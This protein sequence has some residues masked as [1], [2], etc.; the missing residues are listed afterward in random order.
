M[1]RRAGMCWN[2]WFQVN[3]T[4]PTWPGSFDGVQEIRV[5]AANNGELSGSTA[6]HAF[7]PEYAEIMS[8]AMESEGKAYSAK[9]TSERE[10]H[11]VLH[12]AK[13]DDH[14]AVI[15]TPKY[16]LVEYNIWSSA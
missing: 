15:F 11:A 7:L 2:V 5:I 4:G 3:S 8:F 9:R 16:I 10:A 14:N 1:Q 6:V 12:R 13:K